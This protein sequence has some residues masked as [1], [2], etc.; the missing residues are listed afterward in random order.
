MKND[1]IRKQERSLLHQVKESLDV[2]EM[3]FKVLH[4]VDRE[5]E[6]V[7]VTARTILGQKKLVENLREYLNKLEEK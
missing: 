4:N 3:L 5:E 1:L 2:N 7:V 6:I